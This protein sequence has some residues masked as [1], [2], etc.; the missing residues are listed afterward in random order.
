[1]HI[2]ADIAN[3]VLRILHVSDDEPWAIATGLPLLVETARLWRSI[4]HHHADGAFHIDGVTGPDEYSALADD[5][6]FTNLMAER[7][8]RGAADLATE[9]PEA[10][11]RLGV[12]DEEIAA[13]REA[14]AAMHVPYDEELGVHPQATGFTRYRRWDFEAIGEDEYPLFLH[15]PYMDLYRSQVVKQADLVAALFVRGDRFTREEKQRNFA[16]YE[17][18]CV[19]D[20]SLSAAIQAVVAAEVGHLELAYDYFGE[21]A[22]MDLDDLEHN[23]RDGLHIASLAGAWMVAVAGFGGL[24]DHDGELSFAPRLPPAL[25]RLAFALGYRGRRLHVDIT[26]ERVRYELLGEDD[27]TL[28]LRHEDELVEIAAG[29]PVEREWRAPDPGEPPHQPEGRAPRRRSPT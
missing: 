24:R 20:S 22:R 18:I 16:Y 7:N 1:V 9:Y 5:N 29:A 17:A 4:G 13:W 23:T 6:V 19:R 2:N 14:A 3:A 28:E 8:L 25:S 10:A 15:R 11:E 12:D 27:D 21:A 26:P